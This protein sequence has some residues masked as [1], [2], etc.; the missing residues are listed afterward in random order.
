MWSD[1][2]TAPINRMQR[3][4]TNSDVIRS[5]VDFLVIYASSLP[6]QQLVEKQTPQTW[7]TLTIDI[8]ITVIIGL[9]V[10]FIPCQKRRQTSGMQPR[11][12]CVGN[13]LFDLSKASASTQCHHHLLFIEKN[14]ACV[15]ACGSGF[16]PFV[17]SKRNHLT[18]QHTKLT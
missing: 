10:C 13:A 4:A 7:R 6:L 5:N 8:G 2:E 14:K 15:K 3:L 18:T 1:G 9:R 16:L 17:V 11:M 12:R